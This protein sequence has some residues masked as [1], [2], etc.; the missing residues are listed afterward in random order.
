MTFQAG[1]F[2]QGGVATQ[3]RPARSAVADIK[4]LRERPR[5]RE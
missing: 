5:G 2:R 3:H 1:R 4:N